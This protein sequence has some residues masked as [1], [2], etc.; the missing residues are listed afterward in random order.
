[1]FIRHLNLN[2][3]ARRANPPSLG[4]PDLSRGS[5]LNRHPKRRNNVL[6]N[7]FDLSVPAQFSLLF[8]L[9]THIGWEGPVGDDV[10]LVQDVL[11]V[12]DEVVGRL[13][14]VLA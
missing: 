5:G 7:E 2:L 10:P 4:T 12:V 1:M 6:Q 14:P 11:R 13:F 3:L 8:S 9:C